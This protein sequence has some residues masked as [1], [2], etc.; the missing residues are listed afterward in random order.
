ML[1]IM[2]NLICPYLQQRPVLY[3]NN[4]LVDGGTGN[5]LASMRLLLTN[6]FHGLNDISLL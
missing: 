2:K 6:E 1:S 3:V 5:Y 4:L